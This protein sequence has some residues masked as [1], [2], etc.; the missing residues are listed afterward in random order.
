MGLKIVTVLAL[1]I[2]VIVLLR[3]APAMD[4]RW[5]DQPAHFWIVLIAAAVNV[6]LNVLWIPRLGY[7][8]CAYASAVAALVAVLL[9]W[10]WGRQSFPV[11]VW[12][13]NVPAVLM[14]SA[15]LLST[16]LLLAAGRG[17]LALLVQIAAGGAAYA[18]VYLA[19]SS[20]DRARVQTWWAGRG[21]AAQAG[22]TP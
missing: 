11:P 9:S 8:G 20:D 1:P 6:G 7:M 15:A 17:P 4:A 19:T 14:G 5:E 3:A 16:E 21:R 2:A 10:H 13:P 18:V 22:G 12:F